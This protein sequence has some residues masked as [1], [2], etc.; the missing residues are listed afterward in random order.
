MKYLKQIT[1]L[2]AFSFAGEAVHALL[3]L[4]VPAAIYG[5]L[6]LF[7]ALCLQII[8]PGQIKESAQ[9]LIAVMPILFVAPTVDLTEHWQTIVPLLLPI[10]VIIACSTVLTVGVSGKL[11]QLVLKRKKDGGRNG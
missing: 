9:W 4:P 10:V 8:D 5:L 7:A 3:P 11:T 6:L 2:L 1:I